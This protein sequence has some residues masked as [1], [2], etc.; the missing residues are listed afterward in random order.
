MKSRSAVAARHAAVPSDRE[1]DAPSGALQFL[2]DLRAR[3]AGAG[4]QHRPRRELFGVA[5]LA[6]MDL[7]HRKLAQQI[8]HQRALIGTGGDDD[9][10]R[11]D[12]AVRSLG[13]EAGGAVP[14]REPRHLDAA[15]D[16][17]ADEIGIGLDEFDDIGRRC[18]RIRVAVRKRKIRQP[19]RPVRK[20]ELQTVPAFAAPALGDSLP[21]E[22]QM[23][24]PTLLEAVAHHE[25]GLAAADHE[26]C[27]LFIRHDAGP[28]D[29]WR[30]APPHE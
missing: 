12:R 27:Y 22:H 23:R 28:C 5:V 18:E 8:R 10:V 24:E 3:R 14:L 21:L 29:A 9:I 19:H 17:R 2:G 4:H 1:I 7:K 25:P 6:G 11:L 16:R 15:A 26:C 13:D 30:A 20:L